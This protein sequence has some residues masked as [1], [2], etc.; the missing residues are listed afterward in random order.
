MCMSKQLS[1][2][3][4]LAVR[5]ARAHFYYVLLI[6]GITILYDAFQLITPKAVLAR[7]ILA[8]LT[9]M[10]T[11]FVWYNARNSNKG[12]GYYGSLI[13]GLVL[14][15]IVVASFITY[16]ERGMSS[17]GVALYAIPLVV[18]AA[19]ASRP[20]LFAAA[21]M[22][23]AAYTLAAVS[24]FVLN[25]N[26][27]YKIELYSTLAFYSIGFFVLAGLLWTL[28]RSRPQA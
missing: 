17:R 1:R 26:E 3:Q 9:L 25:F 11:T 15:D 13:Y 16:A 21:A 19:L 4:T 28:I 7:W 12:S 6:V 2:I 20:A 22:C 8:T 5:L 10:V 23:T 14:I 27:G 24:Y 18:S